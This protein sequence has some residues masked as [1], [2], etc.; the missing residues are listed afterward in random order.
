MLNSRI[1]AEANSAVSLLLLFLLCCPK[2]F[3]VCSVIATWFLQP[4]SLYWTG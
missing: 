4:V 1:Q 2:P 3:P